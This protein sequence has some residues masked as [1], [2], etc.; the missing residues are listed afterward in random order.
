MEHH[1]THLDYAR[2]SDDQSLDVQREQ[3]KAAGCKRVFEEK[4]SG[5]AAD[6]REELRPPG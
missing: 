6:V 3:L 2:V 1:M 4:A 5:K